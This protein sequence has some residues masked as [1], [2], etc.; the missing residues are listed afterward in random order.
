[1]SARLLSARSGLLLRRHWYLERV[2]RRT[3]LTLVV[4]LLGAACT[5]K[6]GPPGDATEL[7]IAVNAPFSKSPFI[8]QT[9]LNGAQLAVD[10]INDAGGIEAG[11]KT[12]TFKLQRFDNALS[13]STALRNTQQ[14]IE[15]GAIAVLDE[16]TG[17]DASWPEAQRAGI[18]VC[19]V[20]QGGLGM[21][22]PEARPNVFRITPT[23][24]GIAFRYAE[25]LVP[26]GLKVALI[27]DDSD[28][29]QG[30]KA[31]F[32]KAFGHVPE[33]IAAE[34]SVPA[35]SADVAPQVL[36][37]RRSG[38]TAVLIWAHS[39]TVAQVIRAIR[40]SKWNVPIYTAP[41]GQDPLV[42][43][44]LAD[45]P[46]WVEGLTFA[47][48]RM[49]AEVGP[50]P[51]LEFQTAYHQAYGRDEVGVQT[52]DGK[53]VFQPPDYAM[54]PYDFVNVLAA[55]IKAANGPDA[56]AVMAALEQVDTR[57]ANGDERGFNEINHEGVVDDDVYF[58]VF[59]DMTYTPV[60]DDALSETLDV[61]PQT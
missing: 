55:A 38:A 37:A 24:N 20:Y 29:G 26:K 28:Y 11:G 3:S 17:L 4:L 33:A 21:V 8:G 31:A 61:I 42:R 16:G 12:Y 6:G 56:G 50:G 15:D 1:L 13:P 40:T 46:Q 59:H 30:G 7:L 2:L 9:I 48:G 54:Y 39:S 43:E 23:D 57:G 58:A 36:D 35:A 22:D 18:P 27:S 5:P 60:Q 49:T 34:V 44:Q 45:H 52:S 47:A 51:F 10:Q 53:D 25:Y 19:V 14:A 41:S 32:D